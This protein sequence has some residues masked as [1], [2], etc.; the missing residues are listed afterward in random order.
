VPERGPLSIR[1]ADIGDLSDVLELLSEGGRWMAAL[2]EGSAWP[3]PFPPAQVQPLLDQGSVYLA[4]LPAL[5][6]VATFALLWEMDPNWG[7]QMSS[8]GYLHRLAVRR[9][10]AGHRIGREIIEWADT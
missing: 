5:G 3:D 9:S 2:G 6:T 4:E 7:S 1:R 8:A 10:L